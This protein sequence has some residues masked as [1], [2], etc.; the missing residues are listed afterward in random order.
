M[1]GTK[2]SA[3]PWGVGAALVIVVASAA[4]PVAAHSPA[5]HRL[6]ERIVLMNPDN[7]RPVPASLGDDIEVRLTSYRKNGLN[8]TWG[9]PQSSD[10]TVLQRTAGA[11]TPDGGA[12]AVF[13]AEHAGKATISAHRSCRPDPGRVCPLVVVPWKATVTV[14]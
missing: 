2:W 10:S 3:V 14:K 6:A 11:T 1:V 4:A 12:S 13:H 7:G 8:Y 9:I 5:S